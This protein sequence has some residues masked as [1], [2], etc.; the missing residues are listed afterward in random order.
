MRH[1]GK[2][3]VIY[4][5]SNGDAGAARAD[6]VL[7]GAAYTEKSGLYVN[8]EGRVQLAN[9]A[10]FPP[11]EARED[12]AI[13][14]ALSEQVGHKLPYDDLD[15]VRRAIVA[16]APHFATRDVPAEHGGADPTVWNNIGKVQKI[17][18]NAPLVSPITDFYLTDPLA[19]ASETLAECSRLFVKRPQPMA[20]E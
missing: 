9:R 3:F 16:E 11:G 18:A 10:T 8:T 19:R 12:W 2:A 13:I 20:A 6:V 1:L 5:G 14:R 15:G 7:P 17:D 4:Q